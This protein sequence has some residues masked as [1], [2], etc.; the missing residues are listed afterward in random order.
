MF[1]FHF[2]GKKSCLDQ[3][4]IELQFYMVRW[5]VSV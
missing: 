3:F 2:L 4:Q 1:Q 5:F